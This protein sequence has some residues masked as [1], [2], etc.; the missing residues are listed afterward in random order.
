MQKCNSLAPGPTFELPPGVSRRNKQ[1]SNRL[2]VEVCG[3]K[4]LLE[5][6]QQTTP[7]CTKDGGL[8][9]TLHRTSESTSSRPA[10][11]RLQRSSFAACDEKFLRDCWEYKSR[12]PE[13]PESFPLRSIYHHFAPRAPTA[14]TGFKTTLP[15]G[16]SKKH[17][18]KA[19]RRTSTRATLV[20][21]YIYHA[22]GID[23]GGNAI[24]LPVLSLCKI[25][26]P[27]DMTP[28]R[29]RAACVQYL[30]VKC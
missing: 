27:S 16:Q 29:V 12:S 28:R 11:T 21:K 7:K 30:C 22:A 3:G 25:A 14:S 24:V 9:N 8:R 19:K 6:P 4:S 5:K 20:T 15:S 1:F 26:T 2:Y 17:A 23:F 13:Q 10:R 18:I